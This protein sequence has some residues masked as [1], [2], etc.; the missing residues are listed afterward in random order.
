[1]S[2]SLKKFQ[3]RFT[4]VSNAVLYDNR[5]S[6]KAKG[7]YAY[8]FSKPDGWEFHLGT[9][10]CE[11]REGRKAIYAAIRELEEYG[12]ITKYQKNDNGKFGGMIYEFIEPQ[13]Q[14]PC[15]E[16]GAAPKRVYGNNI[17]N[18]DSLNNI[19]LNTP[20]YIPPEGKIEH[21]EKG[22][23][24]LFEEFWNKYIPVRCNGMVVG[25]GS[26][27]ESCKKFFR[28]VSQGTSYQDII[29]GLE[30]YLSYCQKNKQLTCSVPVFLNQERWKDDYGEILTEEDRK[31]LELKKRVEN[32]GE[33]R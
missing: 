9:M 31:W 5:L 16:K 11:L 23:E 28:L 15:T 22:S 10:R 17:S 1:M 24:I 33:K 12:Y 6:L 32:Y 29:T 18:T 30:A 4:Q 21:T 2:D 19:N 7:I 20:H 14:N 25:K 26:K 8:L 27:K 13:V 3:V